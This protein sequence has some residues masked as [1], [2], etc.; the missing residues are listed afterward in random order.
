MKKYYFFV[1]RIIRYIV[2]VVVV[3]SGWRILHQHVVAAACT[4][5]LKTM[6]V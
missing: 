2:A 6:F 3:A 1:N 5:E 4:T